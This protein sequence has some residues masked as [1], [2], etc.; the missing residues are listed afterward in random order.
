MCI[1][2]VYARYLDIHKGIVYCE[3]LGRLVLESKEES[4]EYFTR[5]TEDY[6][7]SGLEE[8]GY[9]FCATCGSRVYSEKELGEHLKQGHYIL[10]YDP[11][12][13]DVASEEAP[14]AD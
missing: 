3:R 1:N 2:C 11:F 4:C 6:L 9:V 7:K 5:V 13:D 14:A 10:P 8:R 12:S